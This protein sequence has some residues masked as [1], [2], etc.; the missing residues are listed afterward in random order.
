MIRNIRKI[1]TGEEGE[2]VLLTKETV[3]DVLMLTEGF[4]VVEIDAED[5]TKTY[6]GVNYKTPL[7]NKR[8]SE[9]QI[10]VHFKGELFAAYPDSFNRR[11]E[12]IR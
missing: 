4:Q 5:D 1:A 7:G 2:A 9:G 11:F 3:N 8:I 10:L 6:V 12:Y